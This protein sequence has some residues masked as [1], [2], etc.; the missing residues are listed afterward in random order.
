MPDLHRSALLLLSA[1]A[2]ASCGWGYAAETY[3]PVRPPE[4]T[5]RVVYIAPTTTAP[6]VA[7][8]DPCANPTFLV[9]RIDTTFKQTREVDCTSGKTL[10]L[11]RVDINGDELRAAQLQNLPVGQWYMLVDPMSPQPLDRAAVSNTTLMGLSQRYGIKYFQ[12]LASSSL[13]IYTFH[14]PT[15]P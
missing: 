4:Q 14:D 8:P 11:T 5:G 12:K 7:P 10:S 3:R 6:V 15:S 2:L 9:F 1:L 13:I